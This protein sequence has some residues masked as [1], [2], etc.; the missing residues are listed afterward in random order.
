MRNK[1]FGS[2]DAAMAYLTG[3]INYERAAPGKYSDANFDLRGMARLLASTGNPHRGIKAIHVAGTK[4]KGSTCIMAAAIL[5]RA[6]HKVGLYTSP[7]LVDWEERI[8]VNGRQIPKRRMTKILGQ[9][10]P[11]IEHLKKTTTTASPTFFEV[12]TTLGW[13]HFLHEKVDYAVVEVGM[14]GRLDATNVINPRVCAIT[15]VSYDHMRHLGK[16]L[17]RIA[18]EKA[19]IIKNGVPVVCGLQRPAAIPVI[20]REAR[21]KQAPLYVLGEDFGITNER[22]GATGSTFDVV[23][24][25]RRYSRLALPAIGRH[26]IVNAAVAVAIVE[27]LRERDGLTIGADELRAGLLSVRL[28]GRTQ[29]VARNPLLVIDG[30]HNVVSLAA[31]REALKSLK[32][33]R[34]ILVFGAMRDKDIGRMFREITPVADRLVLTSIDYP[35][36]ALP[37][38]LAARAKRVFRGPVFLEPTPTDALARARTLAAAE[39]LIAVTGSLYLAGEFLKL[40][41]ARAVPVSAGASPVC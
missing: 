2:Y 14:G 25:G 13:L 7:H 6:R 18:Y 34:C 26:H 11:R 29:I 15:T 10:C 28:P 1:E 33:G 24:W 30:A 3:L 16:T 4:G 36:A 17:G 31:L 35:R 5:E 12:L 21:K 9:L 38:E 27:V 39:D 37:E 22:L 23:T 20:R 8:V 41:R 19:G 32:Y 40:L